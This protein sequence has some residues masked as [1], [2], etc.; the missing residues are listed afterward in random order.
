MATTPP[1]S[2]PSE[3]APVAAVPSS[4]DAGPAHPITAAIPVGGSESHLSAPGFRMFDRGA[5]VTHWRPASSVHPVLFSS[6]LARIGEDRAWRGGIPICAPW[7]AS[8]RDGERSPSHGIARTA[9]W[10]REAELVS[11]TRHSLDVGVDADGRP[12]LLVFE[13]ETQRTDR[14]FHS[15]LTITNAGRDRAPVEAALHT[16]LAVSDVTHVD[17]RGLDASSGYDKVTGKTF[18]PGSPLRFGELVDRIYDEAHRDVEIIDTAWERTLR[19]ERLG[20]TRTVVWNPGPDASPSDLDTD[21]WR[22]F[23]CVEAAAIGDGRLELGPD[24]SHTLESTITVE[25]GRS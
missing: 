11:G 7:F 9:T 8:G 2:D 24:Q 14:A 3:T 12:A 20:A 25:L 6:S 10:L 15:R 17:V 16:Y 5:H 4:N 23:V 19:I 18:P 22:A 13:Y 1:A 21:E